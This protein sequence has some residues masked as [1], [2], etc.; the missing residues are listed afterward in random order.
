MNEKLIGQV[1]ELPVDKPRIYLVEE[2]FVANKEY[3][4]K[5]VLNN[6]VATDTLL[7]QSI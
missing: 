4:G 3:A 5:H 6:G 2:D 1:D 7:M